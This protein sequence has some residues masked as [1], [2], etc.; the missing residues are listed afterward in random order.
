M[1]YY[2]A[3]H[4]SAFLH[5]ACVVWKA[6]CGIAHCGILWK[7]VERATIATVEKCGNVWKALWKSVESATIGIIWF[8]KP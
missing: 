6:V 8:D 2:C 4:Y 1:S 5:K 3:G 7:S